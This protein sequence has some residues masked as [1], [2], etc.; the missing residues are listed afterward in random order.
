MI[1]IAPV[2]AEP[3][4][5]KDILA[6]AN[7]D[8]PKAGTIVQGEVLSVGKNAVMLDLGSLGTGIVYPGEFYDNTTLQKALKSGDTVSAVLLGLED[9]E[10]MGYRELSL[11][12]AQMTTAW[13]DIRQKKESGEVIGT[14]IININKGGL[15]VEVNGVQ[16][17]LPLSQLSAEH[18]PKVEGGDTTKIVQAMQKYRNQDFQVKI[19]DFSEEE[20]RL[21]VSEKAIMEAKM[22]AEVAKY[23]IGDMIEGTITDVTDF[24]AFILIQE[25][26]EGLIHISE[27]DWK[28]IDNPR[29]ILARDQ[30]VSAKIIAIEGGKISL[31]LK[32]LK[33]DPWQSA[34]EKYSVGQKISGKIAKITNYGALI[35]CDDDITGLIPLAEFK[36]KKP[37]ETLKIGDSISV[38]ISSL[39]PQEHKMILKL[40]EISS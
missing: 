2:G 24:G 10:N 39:D 40:N 34:Q 31:S 27:I 29:D 21:I 18:Y 20:K 38:E 16:G 4:S 22:Q 12:R 17:F 30:K 32:A 14:K 8:L 28:I 9:E 15:I 1:S 37:T 19:L 33:P 25:G 3:F 23:N 6:G 35:S 5:M 7:F 36:E 11:K 26:L 13:E